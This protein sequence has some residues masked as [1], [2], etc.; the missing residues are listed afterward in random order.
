MPRLNARW[1]ASDPLSPGKHT[2]AFD[3]KCDGLGLGTLAFN[4]MSG[5]GKGGMG[6]L[7]VDGKV[8]A[9]HRME[10]SVPLIL[11]WDETFDIGADTGTPVD[12]RDYQV[13][14]AFTGK[15]DKLTIAIDRPQLAPEDIKK[16]EEAQKAAADAN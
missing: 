12:D 7:K 13:P 9:E 2:I 11:Q 14:F 15:L 5:I 3:F 6:T 16:L 1:E 4:D 10:R 8:V